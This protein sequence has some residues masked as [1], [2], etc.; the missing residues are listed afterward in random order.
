MLGAAGCAVRGEKALGRS[1]E[2]FAADWMAHIVAEAERDRVQGGLHQPPSARRD[3]FV[4]RT[5]EP[6]F[7]TQIRRTGRDAVPWV[8]V[9]TYEETVW[10]CAGED[11][12]DCE[13]VKSGPVMELFPYRDGRWRP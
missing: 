1:F 13:V 12:S 11:G 2:S 3:G 8:G 5:Y 4:Y 10:R 9:L 6:G 7:R